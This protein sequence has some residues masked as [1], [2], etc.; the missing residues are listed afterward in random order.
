MPAPSG[1]WKARM[2]RERNKTN[3][4]AAWK[5]VLASLTSFSYLTLLMQFMTECKMCRGTGRMALDESLAETLKAIPRRGFVT[6]HSLQRNNPDLTPNAFNNRLER[7][8]RFGLVR[9]E[10]HGKFFHYFRTKN[11]PA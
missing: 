4:S 5:I 11:Q 6:S 8:R 3:H 7:L 1:N 9:R 10:R 2:S